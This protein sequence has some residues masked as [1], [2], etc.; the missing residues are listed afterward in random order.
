MEDLTPREFA[1]RVR[2]SPELAITSALKM[3]A[4]EPAQVSYSGRRIQTILFEHKD[5]EW[6]RTNL[7]ASRRLI[8]R[9]GG[10]VTIKKNDHGFLYRGIDVLHIDEF[11]S[12]YEFHP[13]AQD[14]VAWRIRDY[15]TRQ[16]EYD[17]LLTWNVGIVTRGDRRWGEI[18]LGTG[19]DAPLGLINRAAMK[20]TAKPHANIKSLMS[21]ADRVLDL[22]A[23]R[24]IRERSRRR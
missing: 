2:T 21:H 12:T 6:L 10:P 17:E 3:K 18:D 14:L 7:Q 5:A 22:R 8:E 4:A 15:I 19:P 16:N 1:V 24:G 23:R 20:A 9:C 11:L 13:D